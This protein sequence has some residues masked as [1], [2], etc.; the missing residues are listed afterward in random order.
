MIGT[1]LR[2]SKAILEFFRGLG[3]SLQ[4]LSAAVLHPSIRQ[5]YAHR[6]QNILAFAIMLV[7]LSK[8]MVFPIRVLI[9]FVNL[10][11]STQASLA[12]VDQC[13]LQIG[14]AVPLGMLVLFRYFGSDFF[15]RIFFNTL[16]LS[17]P[18]FAVQLQVRISLNV[19]LGFI[20]TLL[21][22]QESPLD[23]LGD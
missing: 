7:L 21:I 5:C 18:E 22:A 13:I 3:V 23:P 6:I 15:E 16:R 20:I 9:W 8:C 17:D 2:K 19:I 1:E 14:K 4:A 10:F 11:F 12:T